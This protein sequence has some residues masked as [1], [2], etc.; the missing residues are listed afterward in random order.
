MKI[1][2]NLQ[3]ISRISS[4]KLRRLSNVSITL[5]L[6]AIH[7]NSTSIGL[8]RVNASQINLTLPAV[9]HIIEI[10]RSA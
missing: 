5:S 3:N 4:V 1:M 6:N 2:Q 9:R 8:G 10:L 7:I